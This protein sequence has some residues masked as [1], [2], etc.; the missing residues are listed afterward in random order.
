MSDD[1]STDDIERD[2]SETKYHAEGSRV[3]HHDRDCHHLDNATD[4]EEL[5][6]EEAEKYRTC[7]QCWYND[8]SF[9]EKMKRKQKQK[10]ARKTRTVTVRYRR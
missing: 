3:V 1:T 9:E 7:R 2:E 5:D 4:V 10:R 6:G 8:L